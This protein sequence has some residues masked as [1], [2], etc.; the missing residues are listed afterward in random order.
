[1]FTSVT[2]PNVRSMLRTGFVYVI[3]AI[4]CAFFGAIYEAFSHGVYSMY[5]MYAFA[6]PLAGGAAVTLLFAAFP[7]KR[8][9]ST[10]VKQLYNSGIAT[11]TVG[12]VF[13]G[14]LEIYGTT[15]WLVMVYWVVGIGFVAVSLILFVIIQS[16]NRSISREIEV[17]KQGKK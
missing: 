11:L 16:R 4:F 7:H 3:I 13:A 17:A 12:S 2:D 5:M 15:N 8:I 9:P 6:F 1:M 10:L 14:A